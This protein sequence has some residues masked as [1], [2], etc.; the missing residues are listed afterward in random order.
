[1][2]KFILVLVFILATV[3][4]SFG[5]NISSFFTLPNIVCSD[6]ECDIKYMGNAP[7]PSN[8]IIYNWDFNGGIIVSNLHPNY[9]IKWITPGVK[10]IRLYIIK[11]GVHSV[12]TNKSLM[13]TANKSSDFSLQSNA[14]IGQN[15]PIKYIGNARKEAIYNWTF[16]YNA[17]VFSSNYPNYNINYYSE[18]IRTVSLRVIDGTCVSTTNKYI[19][20]KLCDLSNSECN[21]TNNVEVNNITN[22]SALI[23]W[24]EVQ[25][26][27]TYKLQYTK[28]ILSFNW[29]DTITVLSPDSQVQVNGLEPNTNYIVRVFT[30][31]KYNTSPPLF[32]IFSTPYYRFG[33]TVTNFYIS[34]NTVNFP[35]NLFGLEYKVYDL[36]GK[37]VLQ[38]KVRNTNTELSLVNGMYVLFIDDKY[39]KFLIN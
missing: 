1:M 9:K 39:K 18:G 10:Y 37:L 7:N 26:A 21:T 5:Q 24:D 6:M 22:N 11:D 12:V 19:N 17:N 14:C 38:D 32:T 35:Q 33:S 15:I 2:K 16:G 31:C 23:K 34:N 28:D 25:D 29:S 3:S 20:I 4:S 36:C 30:S 13:V 27:T 8:D